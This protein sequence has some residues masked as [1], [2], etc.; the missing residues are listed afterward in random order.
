MARM[1]FAPVTK[2]FNDGMIELGLAGLSVCIKL[3]DRSV[4]QRRINSA[5]AV[6]GLGVKKLNYLTT[7]DYIAKQY[8]RYA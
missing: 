8:A 5:I 7:Y 2:E 4:S 1:R 3:L 6:S